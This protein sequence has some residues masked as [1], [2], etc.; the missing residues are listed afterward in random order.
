[1]ITNESQLRGICYY[2][3]EDINGYFYKRFLKIYEGVFLGYFFSASPGNGVSCR[4]TK[5]TFYRCR[6]SAVYSSYHTKNKNK[7][8]LIN[9][10]DVS[11][12][13]R[14]NNN[15][16]HHISLRVII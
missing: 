13:K 11:Q 10:I 4:G 2:C 1:M 12:S 8:A 15:F 3:I 14:Y 6:S 16:E 9:E 7:E 5:T